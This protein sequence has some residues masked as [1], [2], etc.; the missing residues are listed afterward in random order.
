MGKK[1]KRKGK[2][3]HIEPV[4]R[5][6][7]VNDITSSTVQITIRRGSSVK[8]RE[9]KVVVVNTFLGGIRES[10]TFQQDSSKNGRKFL[11]LALKCIMS[12]QERIET[13]TTWFMIAL[14]SQL[15]FLG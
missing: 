3:D 8:N 6:S 11:P 14:S 13:G 15:G 12:I 10:G 1:E 5:V 4:P 9:R 2:Y 7:I